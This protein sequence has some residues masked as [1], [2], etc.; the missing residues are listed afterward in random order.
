MRTPPESRGSTE[1]TQTPWGTLHPMRI[2][3]E[4]IP[5]D[6]DALREQLDAV[7]RLPTV[8][9]V[10]V[11][12]IHR[13][14]LRSWSTCQAVA[15]RGLRVVPHL[16]AID[17]NPHA[18]LPFLDAL[19]AANVHEVLVVA[20]DAPADMSRPVYDTTSEALVARIKRERPGTNVYVAL[21]PYRQDFSSERAYLKRKI[22]AGADGVFTQPFFDVRL[23]AVWSELV[24]D[25]DVPIFWGATSVTSSR[26]ARYWTRR[27][28]AILPAAFEPTLEHSRAFA[29]QLAD[30]ARERGNHVYYMPIRVDIAAYLTGVV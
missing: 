23:A 25:V 6:V 4:V 9:T 19:D 12:D 5:R 29:R 14:P 20:G 13:F 21:D 8:D 11:P 18:P 3:V 26:S 30:F 28:R 16:R 7:T 27:N 10:N 15:E 2:S 24:R 1:V 17:V 22:E